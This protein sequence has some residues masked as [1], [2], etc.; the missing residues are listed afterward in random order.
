MKTERELDEASDD[1]DEDIDFMERGTVTI[2]HGPPRCRGFR[3]PCPFCHVVSSEDRRHPD[4]IIRE[5]SV[6]H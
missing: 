3:V 5:M 4:E 2:C 6:T 1:L